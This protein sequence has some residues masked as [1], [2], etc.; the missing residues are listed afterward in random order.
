MGRPYRVG[1]RNKESVFVLQILWRKRS[2]DQIH[3][4]PC[5]VIFGDNHFFGREFRLVQ[6]QNCGVAEIEP[7][8]IT[9]HRPAKEQV[10]RTRSAV[11]IFGYLKTDFKGLALDNVIVP[12]DE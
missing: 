6:V 2:D 8:W 5:R 10:V 11:R 12:A 1:S 4:G 3:P 7:H 9:A